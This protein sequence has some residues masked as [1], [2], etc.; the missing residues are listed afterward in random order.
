[1]AAQAPHSG[2]WLQ[3][4][5]IAAIGLRL[6]DEEIRVATGLRLGLK[7]CEPHRCVCGGIVD[8]RGLHSLSCK[9]VG[10]RQQRHAEINDIIWRG[11][12][13]ANIQSV[14]EPPGL[15]RQDGKRPDGM[16]LIPWRR[17]KCLV[18]DATVYDTFAASYLQQTA[19]AAGAAADRAAALK[20][21]KYSD[22][23]QDY[24]FVPVALETSGA[25]HEESREVIS[26]LGRRIVQVTGDTREIS[27]IFQR[28]SAALQRGNY[29]CF[30]NTVLPCASDDDS[31]VIFSSAF[32]FSF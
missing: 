29:L 25:W 17:G 20:I 23:S 16:T 9:K 32:S 3:A 2:D 12:T 24:H 22:I 30:Y 4:L 7:I 27:F 6:S 19:L 26:E 15:S 10:G 21:A 8:G 13:R 18:W 31:R 1:M 28:V 5:P 11:L 14:K